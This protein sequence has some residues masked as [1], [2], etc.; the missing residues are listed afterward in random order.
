MDIGP[1]QVRR[2]TS[3]APKT[4]GGR[5]PALSLAQ[6]EAF[7]AFF[8]TDLGEGALSFTATD[9]FDCAEAT[10]R[11]VGSY[12]VSRVGRYYSI[13]AELEILP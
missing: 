7:E 12:E 10:F 5:T 9:P 2:I 11:F 3:S 13:T 6:V 4:R 1:A 8:S